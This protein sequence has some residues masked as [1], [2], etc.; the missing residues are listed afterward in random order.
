MSLA[1]K[2]TLSESTNHSIL[3]EEKGRTDSSSLDHIREGEQNSQGP[4]IPEEDDGAG[5]AKGR[6]LYLI[7][8]GL[9][10]STLLVG[11][12]NAI[13]AT[14]VPTITTAFSSLDDVGWYGSGFLITWF[15]AL[16]LVVSP[17][18]RD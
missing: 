8:L 5:Y 15:V 17:D 16:N 1:E 9:C 11:L 13:L 6:N 3:D 7:V 10:I 4:A 12:D 18:V 2:G 14:A